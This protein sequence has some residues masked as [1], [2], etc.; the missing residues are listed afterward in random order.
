MLELIIGSNSTKKVQELLALLPGDLVAV[1]SLLDFGPVPEVE[2][3]G[4]TFAENAN[5]KASGYAKQCNAWVLADDSGLSVDALGGAPGVFSARFAGQPTND[6][7]NNALLLQRLAEV[8]PAQRTAHYTCHLSLADPGGNIRLEATGVC[9]GAIGT[10]PAG[11]GGFGYD[12]LFIIPELHR[13]FAELGPMVKQVVSH[14]GRA[15]RQ[16]LPPFLRLTKQETTSA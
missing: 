8:P 2:E 10:Q 14:R 11:T 15:L 4:S 9:H 13:T 6:Q 5:L 1:R 12:P 16:F 7:A 3:T